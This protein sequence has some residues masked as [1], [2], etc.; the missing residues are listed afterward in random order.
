MYIYLKRAHCAVRL[1]VHTNIRK[2]NIYEISLVLHYEP[3][4]PQVFSQ[5]AYTI[6]VHFILY[7]HIVKCTQRLMKL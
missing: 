1:H 7:L 6:H 3:Y 4:G 2:Y 5:Q